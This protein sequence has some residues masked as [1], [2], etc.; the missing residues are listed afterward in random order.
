MRIVFYILLTAC[1]LVSCGGKAT[2]E[3]AN[4]MSED[5]IS[6]T[7]AESDNLDEGF[8]QGRENEYYYDRVNDYLV[9]DVGTGSVREFYIYDTKKRKKIFEDGYTIDLI[10]DHEKQQITYSSHQLDVVPENITP[11]YDVP[12][13]IADE[14]PDNIGC[15]EERILNL[16]TMKMRPSGKY[17]FRY[18]E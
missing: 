3:N 10:V 1:C 18:F 6:D 8:F 14:F 17:Y 12:Q 9:I 15:S 5:S 13:D 16:K 7:R 4:S 11:I 2:T